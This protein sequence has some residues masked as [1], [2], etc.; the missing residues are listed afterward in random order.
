MDAQAAILKLSTL[1][2]EK[3][4]NGI[5]QNVQLKSQKA[6]KKKTKIGTKNEGN[7]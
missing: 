1:R 3:K 2:K 6:Q 7:K 4:K 5:T